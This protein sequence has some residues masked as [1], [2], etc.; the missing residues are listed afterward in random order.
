MLPVVLPLVA[1]AV[2]V[3]VSTNA[4]IW[5]ARTILSKKMYEKISSLLKSDIWIE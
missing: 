3:C 4:V 1:A 2:I 5:T